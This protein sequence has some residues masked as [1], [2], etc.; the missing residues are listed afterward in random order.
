VKQVARG[1][2]VGGHVIVAT[3]GPDAPAR[4]SG[5][6]VMRYDAETLHDEFGASFE[7]VEH[8]TE[9]HETPAGRIQQFVYC[10]CNVIGAGQGKN[11]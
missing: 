3:F 8:V 6:E 5:L 4:C 11:P 1:V 9:A 2:R 7:L 10:Y